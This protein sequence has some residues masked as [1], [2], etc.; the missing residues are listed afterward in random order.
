MNWRMKAAVQRACAA[1]P[2]GAEPVYYGLQAAAG[3][4]RKP[5]PPWERDMLRAAPS[6]AM[7]L[8]KAGVPLEGCRVMEVGTGRWIDLPLGLYLCGAGPIDTFDLHR[9]LKSSLVE[10]SVA[11]LL[12]NPDKVEAL[13]SPAVDR[14]ALSRRL[15]AIA[16]AR[17]A[18]EIMRRAGVRYHAPA[19]ASATGLTAGSIDAHVSYTV[20]EHIPAGALRE[21]LLEARRL[22]APGGVL[23]HHVDPS[24]HCAHDDPGISPVNFLQFS[25]QEWRR[26]AGNRFA[27]HNRLRAVEYREIFEDCGFEILRW[28]EHVDRRSIDLLKS[29][30][31][32]DARFRNMSPEALCCSVFRVLARPRP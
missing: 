4:L 12:A 6:M 7:W 9:Y 23:L 30:F 27:Y 22:L 13:F 8:R 26:Y 25:E 19:D 24:D 15:Q 17:G 14:S 28:E 32:L 3:R 21:I 31:P 29:G 20:F 5:A 16:D 1:L 10:Q 2:I 11:A 18:H